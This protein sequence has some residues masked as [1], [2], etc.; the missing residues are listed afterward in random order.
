MIN[1]WLYVVVD[2]GSLPGRLM[3]NSR[4]M[5]YLVETFLIT[6]DNEQE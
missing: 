6:A 4:L 3:V 5:L 2:A 1:D